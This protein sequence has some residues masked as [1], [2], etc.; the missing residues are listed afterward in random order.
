M[1]AT[2]SNLNRLVNFRIYF[3][4]VTLG[5]S[6]SSIAQSYLNNRFDLGYQDMGHSI[7]KTD[8]GFVICSAELNAG[9]GAHRNIKF[10]R[11]SDQ[12]NIVS[13][14]TFGDNFTNYYSFPGCLITSPDLNDGF[15]LCGSKADTINLSVYGFL[16]K[17]NEFGD[18]LWMKSYISSEDLFFL[19][20]KNT[21]DGGYI[22]SGI[23]YEFDTDG[24]A[25]LMKVDSVGN[26][27]WENHYGG[28]LFESANSVIQTTDGGYLFVGKKRNSTSWGDGYVVKT[29]STGTMQWNRSYGGSFE[30][31]FECCFQTSNDSTI[32]ISGSLSVDQ[33][34]PPVGNSFNKPYF[35][36]MNLQGDTLWT[37]VYGD[38]LYSLNIRSCAETNDGGIIACGNMPDTVTLKQS[39]LVLKTNS[40]GNLEWFQNYKQITC[41][42]SNNVIN[43]VYPT[44][45]GGYYLIGVLYTVSPDTGTQDTWILA[46]DSL[47]CDYVNCTG[48]GINEAVTT[49]AAELF[50][51][52]DQGWQTAFINADNLKGRTYNLTIYDIAGKQI[53]SENGKLF[54]SYFNKNFNCNAFSS[55]IYLVN[56]RTEKENISRKFVIH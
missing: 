14:Y 51:Y 54:S 29:N 55:G 41:Q 36:K 13:T 31:S 49:P 44:N 25:L 10:V 53:F 28:G 9:P 50:V 47:G 16:M 18:S 32:I 19:D 52:Y 26:F 8:S 37:R 34:M 30:D 48:V 15:I 39:G 12:L 35:L 21:N 45:S 24:D 42:N 33:I 7:I 46:I 22:I 6:S 56:F 40:N 1:D 20:V 4:V 27:M 23:T 38:S 17:L 2:Q 43:E 3:L 11:F 5:F